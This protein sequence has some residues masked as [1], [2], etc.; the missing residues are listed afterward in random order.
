MLIRG[1]LAVLFV[2][3]SMVGCGDGME[4][5][6]DA[7]DAVSDTQ[8]ITVT[9]QAALTWANE[10]MAEVKAQPSRL[11]ENEYTASSTAL[12]RMSSGVKAKNRNV[13]GTLVT[14]LFQNSIGYDSSD[15]YNSFNKA[16]DGSCEA[17]SVDGE[18]RGTTSPNAS[19]YRYKIANCGGTGPIKFTRRDTIGAVRKGDVL[20][21]SYPERTDITGH[22]MI[23]RSAPVADKS[24]PA[25]PSG[26]TAYAVEII[27]S[28]S[29]PHGSAERYPDW[30]GG[31]KGQGMGSGTFV[32]YAD[33]KGAVVASRWSATD[34]TLSRTST[35]RLAIG[36]LR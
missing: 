32:L 16:M 21:V 34:P 4:L 13:C 36:G 31:N 30:R 6:D 5:P 25:G 15:F 14:Q 19:Q 23:V 8:A 22:V 17:G 10:W 3:V 33:A 27:D 29:T 20:A 11:T 24:L 12:T 9:S 26:S 35:D 2:S 7:I 1:V 28:T 18:Q